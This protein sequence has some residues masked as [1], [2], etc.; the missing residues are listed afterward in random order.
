MGSFLIIPI[1]TWPLVGELLSYL[2]IDGMT[3]HFNYLLLTVI[4]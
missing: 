2:L 3:I 1:I 4:M